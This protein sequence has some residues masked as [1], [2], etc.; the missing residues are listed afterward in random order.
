VSTP[1]VNIALER[2]SWTEVK[3]ELQLVQCREQG[4]DLDSKSAQTC[5]AGILENI[6]VFEN[7]LGLLPAGDYGS[8]ICGVFKIVVGVCTPRPL[9]RTGSRQQ[10]A[11]RANDVRVT[12][13]K[14]LADI[15]DWIAH[16]SS[17][18]DLYACI[19]NKS[20]VLPL[21]KKMA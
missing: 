14:A 4:K 8:V 19:E 5:C 1:Q 7:W 18:R 20:L 6:T 3:V 11:N 17:Y 9:L 10:A 12:I 15:P 21:V 13:L 16:A 2:G